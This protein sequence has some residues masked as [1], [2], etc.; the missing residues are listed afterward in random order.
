MV[1]AIKTQFAL[2]VRMSLQTCWYLQPKHKDYRVRY[3]Q[4]LQRQD[5]HYYDTAIPI[6]ARRH[7]NAI[8]GFKITEDC[9]LRILLHELVP[10]HLLS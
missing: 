1:F 3:L 10:L 5:T 4:I 9:L 2:F 8:P 6:L 7:H